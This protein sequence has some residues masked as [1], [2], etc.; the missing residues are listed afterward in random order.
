VQL[1]TK[2]CVRGSVN[3]LPNTCRNSIA[4][5]TIQTNTPSAGAG[6]VDLVG[7]SAKYGVNKYTQGKVKRQKVRYVLTTPKRATIREYTPNC[8]HRPMTPI[9]PIA[10]PRV[11][12]GKPK[13]PVNESGKCWSAVGARGVDRNRYQR[14]L[15]VATWMCNRHAARNVK[16]T[17]GVK[18][19]R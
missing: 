18:M 15:N 4:D 7:T 5:I 12:G 9:K 17:F 14:L 10:K 2:I 16:Q 8:K 3:V 19:R 6:E 1:L 13:P 11:D